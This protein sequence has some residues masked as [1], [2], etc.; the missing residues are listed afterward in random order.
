VEPFHVICETCHA[1]LK[2]RSERVIGEIHAC[3]KCDSMVHIVPPLGWRPAGEARPDTSPPAEASLPAG[4]SLP[5]LLWS[6]CGLGVLV[7]AGVAAAVWPRHLESNGAAAP[8]AVANE[9]ETARRDATT[10]DTPSAGWANA[11]EA[12]PADQVATATVHEPADDPPLHEAPA[13][14]PGEADAP[15]P[16]LSE[17]DGDGMA[18]AASVADSN[19]PPASASS[20]VES[21]S[22]K[23]VLKFDPL[24]F[25]PAQLSLGSATAAASNES[26]SVDQANV[27]PIAVQ[28]N[29]QPAEPDAGATG[30]G[31]P[32]VTVRIGPGATDALRPRKIAEQLALKV[33]SFEVADMPLVRFADMAS[34]MANVPVTIE[35]A[36]LAMSGLSPRASIIAEARAATL[37]QV[38]HRALGKVRLDFVERN[39]QV[40][41]VNPQR[42]VRRSVDYD[43]S[44][45][46]PPGARDATAVA[47]LVRRFVEP[48][49]WQGNANGPEI[50]GGTMRVDGTKLRVEHVN[51]VHIPILMFCERLRLARGLPQRSRYPAERL[52]IDS[53]YTKLSGRLSQPTTFTF[54]PWT[55]LADVVREWQTASGVT[56]LVD[57]SALAQ[58]ELAPA[59][60]IAC[61]AINRPWEEALDAVLE[62]L[63]L[64]WWA[65]DGETIQIT[66]RAGLDQLQRIEF[67]G[68]PKRM[69]N[70]FA[71]TEGPFSALRRKLLDDVNKG[72]SKPTQLE[73]DIAVDGDR[74]IVLG[75]ATVHRCLFER[76]SDDAK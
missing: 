40:I 62:P 14:R 59:T 70:E 24:D 38:L 64:A 52:S 34:E 32:S 47:D 58:E 49:S 46:M 45:L 11:A 50:A 15:A 57:W 16:A 61:S 63:G 51:R 36:D 44:D 41:I 27:E 26:G 28:S 8:L 6:L 3:P 55:R 21:A 53:P 35:P 74:L 31:D 25:D 69:R 68:V 7:V 72:R 13:A 10:T 20:A 5:I 66:S 65:V 1:R 76:L 71:S 29:D 2:I 12:P 39:G 37:E 19:N 30:V 42:D 75:T 73:V 60:P 17:V 33:E 48:E 67:Y 18:A 23:P 43:V 22:A 56:I 9:G 4:E 54:L